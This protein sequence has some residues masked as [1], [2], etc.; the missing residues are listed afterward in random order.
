LSRKPALP[1]ATRRR[2]EELEVAVLQ[3]AWDELA[4]VGYTRLTI[5]AVA[6]RAATSK[7]VVY[8]RWRSRPILVLAALRAY[9]PMLSGEAP[10]TGDL[11]GD[12][13]ALL[14]R[15]AKRLNEIGAETL[16]G[17]LAEYVGDTAREIALDV[18]AI[19]VETMMTILTR[20][21]A[22]G[23]VRLEHITPR[24]ASLPIDLLRNELLTTRT[25]ASATAIVEIVD[26][27]FLPLVQR[28]G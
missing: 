15:V 17:L 20:A 26:E 27:I 18:R 24:I 4:A 10:N 13:L 2:G 7:A 8:R 6:T 9:A 3:A 23:E 14:R 22:R 1:R 25:P 21:A 12:L 5:E 16:N 19:G 28:N 11:R